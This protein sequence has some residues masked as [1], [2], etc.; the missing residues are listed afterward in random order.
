MTP[1]RSK[2]RAQP[3]IVNGERFASKLEAR[4]WAELQILERAGE[5]R[6]LR[7]QVWFPLTVNGELVAHYVADSV[8][9]DKRESWA[10]VVE[11]QKSPAT[12]KLSTYRLKVKLMRACHGIE[13]REYPQTFRARLSGARRALTR[14]TCSS[15]ASRV[16]AA[17]RG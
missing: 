5:I 13:I 11:D 15:P 1:R 4:R 14:P 17:K 3:Q 9:E 8:Y 7:R 16:E 6:A 10:L 12:R 2:Y